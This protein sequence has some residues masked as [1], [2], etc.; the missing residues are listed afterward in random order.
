MQSNKIYLTDYLK[1]V[2]TLIENIGDVRTV[3]IF[4][5]TL[6]E[7]DLKDIRLDP[8]KATVLLAG[9]GGNNKPGLMR[10]EIECDGV[11][12]AYVIAKTDK[13]AIGY[14]TQ[15]QQVA[16][17]VQAVINEKYRYATVGTRNLPQ[18]LSLKELTSNNKKGFGIWYV[19]WQQTVNLK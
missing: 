14:S 11:F 3:T 9:V 18:F 17:D 13:D 8:K 6:T 15:A 5:G 7:D 10:G 2:K 4:G 16:Q 12:S 19:V 1:E